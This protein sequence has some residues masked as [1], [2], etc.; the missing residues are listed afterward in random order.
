MT[1]KRLLIAI[2]GP[3][4]SGKGTLAKSLSHFFKIPHIDTGKIY[5]MFALAIMQN[6]L[7]PEKT[8]EKNFIIDTVEGHNQASDEH[9]YTELVGQIASKVA[10]NAT[11][12][13]AFNEIFAKFIKNSKLGLVMD[14]RDI[15]S[16]MPNDAVK[17]F[18]TAPVN[19]R[20]M[21][22]FKELKQKSHAT[23]YKY[24][25]LALIKRDIRDIYRIAS[26]L[27]IHKNAIIIDSTKVNPKIMLHIAISKIKSH[28]Q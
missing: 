16:I 10:K 7:N 17:I 22:R 8:F 21:R 6:S 13:L 28:L 3:S 12:R 23:M 18:I 4:A 24:T 11:H 1:T 14:G 9:L 5:R 25:L 27:K 15:A 26:P 2:D 20:A 19:I